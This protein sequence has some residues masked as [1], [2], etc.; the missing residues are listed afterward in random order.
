MLKASPQRA[1]EWSQALT[2][3]A[4]NWMAEAK[5]SQERDTSSTRGPQMQYDPYGNV[6]FGSDD[7]MQQQMNQRGN[8]PRPVAAGR[9]LDLAPGAEWIA[10]VEAS[11]RPA[12]L[13]QLAELHLKVKAE[14][15]AFPYIESL[16]KTNPVEAR[17]LTERFIEVWGENHDPNADKRRTNRYMYIYG[18]N[19]QS[20]GIPLTRSKQQRNLED[21]AAWVT[22]LRALPA[23]GVDEAK[24]AAAFLRTHSTAEVY[25]V[26]DV[27]MVFGKV[28]ELKSNM[29]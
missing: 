15:D 6:F 20:D 16:A 25:R 12:I 28:G 21:L 10:A 24:I 18:Y 26:E 19:P 2:L 23:G 9:M 11:L 27:E 4:L 29:G 8:Q 13:K 1:G 14:K 22:K 5:Y 17:E 7:M 3:L